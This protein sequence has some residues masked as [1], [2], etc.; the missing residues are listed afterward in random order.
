[1]HAYLAYKLE[2]QGIRLHGVKEFYTSHTCPVCKE[3]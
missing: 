3:N 2:I 1:M